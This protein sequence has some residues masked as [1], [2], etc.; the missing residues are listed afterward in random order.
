MSATCGKIETQK[1]VKLGGSERSMAAFLQ[2][3]Q[4]VLTELIGEL[5]FHLENLSRS[6]IVPQS[7]GHLLVSHWSFVALSLTPQRGHLVF[8]CGWE[9]ENPCSCWD[10]GHAVGHSGV[11]Q[12]LKQKVKQTHPLTCKNRQV[13]TYKWRE[14]GFKLCRTTTG[15]ANCF[16]IRN[17]FPENLITDRVLFNRE[18]AAVN[19][20]LICEICKKDFTDTLHSVFTVKGRSLI[21]SCGIV[22]LTLL[23]IT[24]FSDQKKQNSP[25]PVALAWHLSLVDCVVDS[26]FGTDPHADSVPMFCAPETSCDGRGWKAALMS[27]NE[28]TDGNI[29]I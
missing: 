27:C 14:G 24:V 19:T 13:F 2:K 11:L 12:H 7:A 4:C 18:H 5:L 9:A 6:R 28:K 20:V 16:L 26:K 23:I 3:Y 17:P 22:S 10:P 21:C 29:K 1:K 8:V 15:P 25:L